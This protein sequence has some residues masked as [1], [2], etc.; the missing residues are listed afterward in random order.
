[1]LI[2][3]LEKAVSFVNRV[4][5]DAPRLNDCFSVLDTVPAVHD[6]PDAVDPGRVHGHVEFDGS[7]IFL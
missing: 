4:F 7:V 3:R 5:M 6:R 1:M 2:G